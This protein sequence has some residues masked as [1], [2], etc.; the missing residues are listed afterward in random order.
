M[1][2]R[3]AFLLATTSAF[4]L[5]ACDS[6]EEKAEKHF[7]AALEFVQAGDIERAMVEFRN[8][9]DLNETHRTARISYAELLRES[10]RTADAYAQYL[11]LNEQFP[12]D[13]EALTALSQLAVESGRL[14]DA[15]RFSS[16]ALKIDPANIPVRIT[17]VM[18]DYTRAMAKGDSEAMNAAMERVPVLRVARPDDITLRRVVITELLRRGELDGALAEL[19]LAISQSSQDRSLYALRLAIHMQRNDVEAVDAELAT[20]TRTFP[21]DP[22][23]TAAIVEWYETRG[24][25]DRAETY[26][27]DRA[28]ARR[29]DSATLGELLRFLVEKRGLDAAI[30]EIDRRLA[31]DGQTTFLRAALASLQFDVGRHDEAVRDLRDA[32]SAAE[33]Q[34][35]VITYKLALAHMLKVTGDRAGMQSVVTE[36]LEADP[37]ETEALK[38]QGGW[39][40]DEDKTGEAIAVLGRALDLAPQDAAVMTLLSDA[41]A[42]DGERDLARQY[43]AMAARA[44]DAA[45]EESLRYARFLIAEGDRLAAESVLISALKRSHAHT[46]LLQQLGEVYVELEDWLR[47]EDVAKAIE[48]VG[49]EDAR[50]RAL[51]IRMAVFQARGQNEAGAAYL[52]TVTDAGTSGRMAQIAAIQSQLDTGQ[53]AAAIEAVDRLLATSPDDA[54]LRYIA[55]LARERS[56]DLAAASEGYQTLVD[57]GRA[58]PQTWAGLARVLI[59]MPGRMGDAAGVLDQAIEVHPGHPGLMWA[60][61][62]VH[63]HMG[64]YDQAIAIYE[65]L[66]GRDSSS[67]IAANNL[68]SLLST[69]RAGDPESLARARVVARRL[70]GSTEAPF[71]DTYGWIAYLSGDYDTARKELEAAVGVLGSDPQVRYHL[72]MTYQALGQIREAREQYEIIDQIVAPNDTRDFVKETRAFLEDTGPATKVD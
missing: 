5:V 42:R 9:F 60:R 55:A 27:R 22:G 40:I 43:L 1:S 23:V 46:G 25:T 38:L 67:A 7:R 68:A 35:D 32:I 59:L 24:A 33:P 36:I 29:E 18:L 13:I 65:D 48:S 30:A 34:E 51:P 28:D 19:D 26:L 39:L 45:P 57:E 47:A 31:E 54:E 69:H 64:E 56:G 4:L 53:V 8:V 63:E 11:Q 50:I 21:D 61:A 2:I 15:E 3:S 49:T 66:Y 14:D 72:A 41:Y 52:E 71:Q 37:G 16:A 12:D 58:D 6:P 70:R 17:R 10:G 20:L 62:S 44:S